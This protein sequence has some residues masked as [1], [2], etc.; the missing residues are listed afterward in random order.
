[1]PGIKP[2]TPSRQVAAE[3]REQ[4]ASG[5]YLP[6]HQLPP[7]KELS[8]LYNVT[9]SVMRN[10]LEFLSDEGVVVSRLGDGRYAAIEAGTGRS[11]QERLWSTMMAAI[12]NSDVST[13]EI[14]RR[15]KMNAMSLTRRIRRETPVSPWDV[16]CV[17]GALDKETA[18]TRP[19]KAPAY[20]RIAD[21][22]RSEIA[23]GIYEPGEQ[24][25]PLRELAA[26]YRVSTHPVRRA[27]DELIREGLIVTV[28]GDATYV[29]IPKDAAE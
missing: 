12:L 11:D 28:H 7:T 14:A 9:Q 8:I 4:I 17:I 10:A 23:D 26:D 16:R 24:L 22:L 13:R 6:G 2:R 19:L 15:V 5:L 20:R 21:A 25:P 18:V 27:F 1:M 29:A 3:L